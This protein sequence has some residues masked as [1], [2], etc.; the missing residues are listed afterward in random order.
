MP[1]G[2]ALD[3]GS[4]QL[5]DAGP[6]FLAALAA[7]VLAAS[8]AVV[9]GLLACTA[10]KHQ[11]RH[12]RAGTLYLWAIG[13]VSA[14]ATVMAALRWHHNW[15]LFL[16][17]T[18]AFGCALLG[19]QARRRRPHRWLLWHGAAMAL[20]YI[21]LLTG[22][23]VDNGPQLPLWDRLPP[24]TYWLLPAAVGI[25]LTWRSLR[26]N[27]AIRRQFSAQPHGQPRPGPPG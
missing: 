12:P 13:V 17:A 11:G 15:H 5:P 18:L 21:A 25:P 24:L 19:R 3:I 10:R 26:R 1:D 2:T 9:A 6:V 20:S 22:F 23:Y 8:T 14:T 7:H 16:I 4:L 27:G